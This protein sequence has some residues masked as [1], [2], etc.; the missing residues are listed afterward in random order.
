MAKGRS[1]HV[2]V[3]QTNGEFEVKTLHGCKKD[4]ARMSQI[5]EAKGFQT[6]TF[7]DGEAL[8]KEKVK[9]EIL[10][11]ANDLEAGDIFLFTFSGH[12]SH[13]TG[14]EPDFQEELLL[15][16]DCLVPDDYM[17]RVLWSKFKKG[18]RILGIADCCHSG[19]V[20]MSAPVGVGA[21]LSGAGIPMAAHAAVHRALSDN[22]RRRR[23][24][25]PQ[26]GKGWNRGITF[27]DMTRIG[28]VKAAADI[29]Q[30]LSD[31]LLAEQDDQLKA[32]LLTLA[33]CQDSEFAE[34]GEENGAFTAQLL[35]VWNDGAFDKN[36]DLFIKA[37]QEP[38]DFE[39]STQHPIMQK[40]DA[41]EK[42][43]D[44]IPFTINAEADGLA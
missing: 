9:E 38:F 36:Y 22:A 4:A 19:T 43:V 3:D 34:D 15:F 11:A 42:F 31:E 21:A 6:K 12:G 29:Q 7:L 8:F 39:G 13:N 14:V 41:D 40:D 44:Q 2:G 37:I 1:V 5:A 27:T 16:H 18:V 23:I 32:T 24:P 20:L 26:R 25:V 30:E 33:A 28:K 17:R 10:Q 35:K